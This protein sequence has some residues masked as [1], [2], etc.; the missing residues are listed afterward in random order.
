MNL[1]TI[2]A[3]ASLQAAPIPHGVEQGRS[4]LALAAEL[5]GVKPEDIRAYLEWALANNH[6]LVLVQ[7]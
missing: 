2:Q 3:P 4:Q 1:A 6:R 5:A 7:P